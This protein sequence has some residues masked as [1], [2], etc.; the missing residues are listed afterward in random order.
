[1]RLIAAALSDQGLRREANEDNFLVRPD[2]GLYVV[3]DGM[4]GHAAGEVASRLAI[5]A[6][7]ASIAGT[8][9]ADGDAIVPNQY[10]PALGVDGT[11]LQQAHDVGRSADPAKRKPT[12]VRSN[13]RGR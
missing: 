8:V 9:S 11:R 3:A 2:L 6:I 13:Q 12:A 10:N 1:M 4:G 5:D 7:E